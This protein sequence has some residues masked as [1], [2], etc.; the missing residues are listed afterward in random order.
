L[1]K[2]PKVAP[3][4]AKPYNNLTNIADAVMPRAG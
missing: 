4:C 3:N 1:Q 2:K